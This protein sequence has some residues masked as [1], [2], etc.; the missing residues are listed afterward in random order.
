MHLTLHA[1]LVPQ[2]VAELWRV[3]FKP[4]RSNPPSAVGAVDFVFLDGSHGYAQVKRD[5]NAYW[6]RLRAGGVLAG[7]GYC[8]GGQPPLGCAGCEH[9]PLCVDVRTANQTGVVRAVHEWLVERGYPLLRLY[10]T[11]GSVTNASMLAADGLGSDVATPNARADPTWFVVKPYTESTMN[12][13][14]PNDTPNQPKNDTLS[15]RT[16]PIDP[17][18]C[19]P[20][21]CAYLRLGWLLSSGQRLVPHLWRQRACASSHAFSPPALPATFGRAGRGVAP[22]EQLTLAIMHDSSPSLLLRHQRILRSY[23]PAVRARVHLLIID[24]GSPTG[25]DAA[26]HVP[27]TLGPPRFASLAIVRIDQQLAWNTGGARNLAFHL[28]RT[29]RVLVLDVSTPAPPKVIAAALRLPARSLDGTPLVHRFGCEQQDHHTGTKTHSH[30]GSNDKLEPSIAPVAM[31]IHRRSYWAAGGC[32]EDFTGNFGQVEEHFWH[33][34]RRVPLRSGG[35]AIE[36]HADLT[37]T[38][39]RQLRPR[40]AAAQVL[41]PRPCCLNQE[42]STPSFETPSL[43]TSRPAPGAPQLSPPGSPCEELALYEK[44]PHLVARCADAAARHAAHRSASRAHSKETEANEML[45]RW[46]LRTGRWANEFLRFTWSVKQPVDEDARDLDEAWI[47]RGGVR[48]RRR[49]RRRSSE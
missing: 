14:Q 44:R 41:N 8:N 19:P 13:P 27:P 36:Q 2:S 37:L 35:L 33:R 24:D 43:L 23:P 1:P 22:D 49:R 39:V 48:A 7:S 25:L 40:S 26:S 32:D 15:A 38:E 21:M 11:A 10:H 17:S 34:A 5:L 42:C 28:A 46:K 29:R 20:P 18:P 31:L 12:L 3:P 16:P 30:H 47:R 45:Y 4:M 9:V 6:T